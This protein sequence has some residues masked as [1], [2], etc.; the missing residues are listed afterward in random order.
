MSHQ[1]NTQ[2][3][4][5]A[6]EMVEIPLGKNGFQGKA[7][8]DKKF[9]YLLNYKWTLSKNGYAVRDAKRYTN[10]LMHHEIV[11]K[12]RGLD[13]D[14]INRDKLDNRVKNLRHVTRSINNLNSAKPRGTMYSEYRGITFDKTR[15]KWKAELTIEKKTRVGYRSTEEEAIN[16]RKE[17]E[18]KYLMSNQVNTE[19]LERA[20]VQIDYWEGTLIAK[21]L[22]RDI[23]TN[24]LEQLKYDLAKAEAQ[25][26]QEE[27][28][29]YNV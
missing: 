7:I 15:G 4:E 25:A 13:V 21:S 1:A 18:R 28:E 9:A 19:L 10:Y 23:E 29:A 26:A 11:G 24:D 8:V 16:L 17:L 22:R 12:R 5:R 27:M 2:L 20:A 14:H 3:L 6:H